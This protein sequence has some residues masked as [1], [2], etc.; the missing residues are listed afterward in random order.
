[1]SFFIYQNYPNDRVVIHKGECGHC[2]EGNGAQRN[3]LGD[4]N[5][6][7]HLGPNNGY[8][9]YQA[10]VNAAEQIAQDMHVLYQNCKRCKPHL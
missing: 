10:C 9:T 5:G 7:W 8:Q 4:Q 3:L 2:N 6:L 1:M